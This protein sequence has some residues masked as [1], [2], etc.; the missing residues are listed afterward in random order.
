[1]GIILLFLLF[2]NYAFTSA[3]N[4]DPAKSIAYYLGEPGAHNITVIVQFDDLPAS[5][6]SFLSIANQTVSCMI[7]DPVYLS[8]SR[9]T[10]VAVSKL[11]KSE[12]ELL[13]EKCRSNESKLDLKFLQNLL[14]T[15]RSGAI[16]P[17]TKWCGP[18]SIA[19]NDQDLG[20]F[21]QLDTCCRTHDYCPDQIGPEE[22]KYGL[23]NE[24][25]YYR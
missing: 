2:S 4:F 12:M 5:A 17:G 11:S 16:V 9:L 13:L 7:Y 19:Q 21:K 20:F 3:A 6:T 18:G 23:K 24:G 10:G 1:M 15:K 8:K 22:S 14:A 25:R